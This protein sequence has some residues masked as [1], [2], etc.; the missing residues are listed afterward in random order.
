MKKKKKDNQVSAAVTIILLAML[1][2]T[3]FI[4]YFLASEDAG[5]TVGSYMINIDPIS[6]HIVTK[7][8]EFQ[9]VNANI[10]VEFTEYVPQTDPAVLN[11]LVSQA[12]ESLNYEK[13]SQPGNISYVQDEILAAISE[14]VPSS[15]IKGAYVAELTSGN[16]SIAAPL[17]EPSST[18]AQRQGAAR[19]LFSGVGN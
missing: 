15:E 9:A 7:D 12:I 19:R 3:V 8:G 16:L 14:Y 5:S 11:M 10:S 4:Y 2:I 13:L 1:A 18:P 6:T 17:P